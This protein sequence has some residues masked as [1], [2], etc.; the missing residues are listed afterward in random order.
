MTQGEVRRKFDE[1]VAFAEVEQFIDTPVKR[2]SSGMYVRLAFAVAAH[3]EPEILI[4]DEVLAVGDAAFQKKCL[5]KMQ[6]VAADE[7]RTI[8]FVSH[9]MAAM[10]HLCTRGLFLRQG[11]VVAAD[12]IERTVAAFL[13]ENLAP[14]KADWHQRVRHATWKI[15]SLTVSGPNQ[16]TG[17]AIA[18]QP[19]SLALEYECG[20]PAQFARGISISC[21]LRSEERKV[22]NLWSEFQSGFSVKPAA[23]GTVQ[24]HIP[25]WPFREGRFAVDVFVHE[26]NE[27]L[28]WIENCATILS[29]DG[30]FYGSGRMTNP[31]EGFMFLPHSWS[32]H[33]RQ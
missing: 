10:Q 5:G 23:R 1:I 16:V 13:N 12:T 6:A 31:G 17:A 4:V 30:D 14:D 20:N 11:R 18:G 19:L 24:C 21:I 8:F 3:L 32:T 2:Y 22:V 9:N 25:S 27:P 15:S 26:G 7:G 33:A 28:E 29:H